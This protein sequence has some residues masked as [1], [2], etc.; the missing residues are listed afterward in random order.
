MWLVNFK[1]LPLQICPFL[2]VIIW[3][4]VAKLSKFLSIQPMN[5]VFFDLCLLLFRWVG[6]YEA[7]NYLDNSVSPEIDEIM[8]IK[9]LEFVGY[10]FIFSW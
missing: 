5:D 7:S 6:A 10:Y 8:M 1:A 4:M 9:V 2:F 3:D